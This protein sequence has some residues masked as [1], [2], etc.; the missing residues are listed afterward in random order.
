MNPNDIELK[1]LNKI[2]EYER[3]SR[4]I[5]N[6]EDID[7]LK[8]KAKYVIKLYLSTLEAFTDLGV[9]IQK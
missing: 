7:E 3:M 8:E 9:V 6:C 1:N 2:F 4:E 5:D